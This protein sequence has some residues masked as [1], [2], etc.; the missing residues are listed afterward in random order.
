MHLPEQHSL[1]NCDSARKPSCSGHAPAELVNPATRRRSRGDARRRST[2]SSGP[3]VVRC[4]V[5]MGHHHDPFHADDTF[6]LSKEVGG[7]ST[8]SIENTATG[9][10]LHLSDRVPYLIRRACFFEGRVD[11]RVDP[12]KACRILALILR[13]EA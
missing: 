4:T 2:R 3:L 10:V 9:E 8:C 7:S 12:A 1:S 5:Y 13:P 6:Y 11:Y